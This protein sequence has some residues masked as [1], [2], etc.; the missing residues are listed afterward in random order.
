M[1]S[2]ISLFFTKTKQSYDNAMENKIYFAYL[3]NDTGKKR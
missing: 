3:V 1:I 2:K